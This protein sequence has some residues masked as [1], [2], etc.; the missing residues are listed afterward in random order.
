MVTSN[1]IQCSPC[2][3]AYKLPFVNIVVYLKH[4]LLLFEMTSK[5]RDLTLSIHLDTSAANDTS[6][7]LKDLGGLHREVIDRRDQLLEHKWR[8]K[9]HH[10]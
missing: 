5:R 3:T 7:D 10:Q 4:I 2:N 1:P 9:G 8:G 6:I